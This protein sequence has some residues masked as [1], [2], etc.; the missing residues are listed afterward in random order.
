MNYPSA[1]TASLDTDDI[2]DSAESSNEINLE[3]LLEK[4]VPINLSSKLQS[5]I[6]GG[7]S[8]KS[9][10]VLVEEMQYNL[11]QVKQQLERYIQDLTVEKS[12]VVQ[13][14]NVLRKQLTETEGNL[15]DARHRIETHP[16]C[17]EEGYADIAEFEDFRAENERLRAMLIDYGEIDERQRVY[18]ELLEDKEQDIKELS[19][20]LD[21]YKKE[22]NKLLDMNEQLRT[23]SDAEPDHLLFQRLDTLEEGQEDVSS[24]IQLSEQLSETNRQ[25]EKKSYDLDQMQLQFEQERRQFFAIQSQFE[26]EKKELLEAQKKLSEESMRCSI[27]RESLEA[28][29]IYFTNAQKKIQSEIEMIFNLADQLTSDRL[30]LKDEIQNLR[31]AVTAKDRK[32]E[33]LQQPCQDE[34]P[35]NSELI[36]KLKTLMQQYAD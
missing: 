7:Y 23:S 4:G 26:A 12:S 24:Y 29:R 30:A 17:D 21:Y 15:E 2:E 6:I 19:Q 13:E 8:K 9:V 31:Q 33:K 10:E 36:N 28:D 22:Y 3:S 25:L 11:I 34:Y 18:T 14:C 1:N 35:K 20:S 32:I 27:E 5:S 16:C